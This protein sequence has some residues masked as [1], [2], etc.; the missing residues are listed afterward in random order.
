MRRRLDE[1][2]EDVADDAAVL[3]YCDAEGIVGCEDVFYGFHQYVLANPGSDVTVRLDGDCDVDPRQ[4]EVATLLAEDLGYPKPVRKYDAV[5]VTLDKAFNG[6]YG[7]NAS[8][9]YTKLRGNF[10][11]G[12]KSDNNQTDT[13]L[14]Q[15]F[16]QPGLMEGAYG[17][18][19]NGRKHSFKFYGRYQ[20]LSWLDVGMNLL[21]ESPRTFSCYGNYG[22]P[23]GSA[24]QIYGSNYNFASEYG[25][26]S[27]W[28]QQALDSAV[29][30]FVSVGDN[31]VPAGDTSYLVPRGTAFKS[32]WN[33][34][35]NLGI[36][37]DLGVL[38]DALTGSRF[39][40]DVFNLFNW[41]QKLDYN[42]FGD[43]SFGGPNPD[44]KKVT[45]YQTPRS[46]RFTLAMRFG[47]GR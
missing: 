21:L 47:E 28:C 24:P 43:I 37:M 20:A 29:A 34:E 18:L 35:I 11:G 26:A 40:I 31:Y 5:Q 44:F 36:G 4:C 16:D 23:A 32:D 2:L 45:G 12:V 17:D 13:G 46:V 15:D 3:A 10:E 42:E 7:F 19:A 8:Y 14:T 6:R 39:R 33:K 41:K 27:Y 38:G 1:T 9:V 22:G 25:A 30:E